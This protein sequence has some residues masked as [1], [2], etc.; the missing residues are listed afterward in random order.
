V[1]PFPAE[2]YVNVY[3]RDITERKQAEEALRQRTLEL[4]QL[5]G[6]L[7]HQVQE[8]TEDLEA[9]NEKLKIEIDECARIESA[10]KKSESSFGNSPWS[11]STLRRK[12]EKWLPVKS[13][14]ASDHPCL[15]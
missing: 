3:G 7:E 6:T 10:L 14:T 1:T 8:R 9:A 12:K 2:R 4:Q 13:M 11:S 15:P 5:T